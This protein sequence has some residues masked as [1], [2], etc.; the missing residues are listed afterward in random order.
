MRQG[1]RKV[2]SSVG[3]EL[4]VAVRRRSRGFSTGVGP[5]GIAADFKRLLRASTSFG[6][7]NPTCYGAV[8]GFREDRAEIGTRCGNS[9]ASLAASLQKLSTRD[10]RILQIGSSIT[11]FFELSWPHPKPC[12]TIPSITARIKK[13]VVS[14]AS[15]TGQ[16]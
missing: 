6:R 9:D 15:V 2:C 8:A 13:I 4:L 14:A 3:I 11:C 16:R 5:S 1:L 7:S 12:A 10:H